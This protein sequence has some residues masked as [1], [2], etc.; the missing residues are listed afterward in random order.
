MFFPLCVRMNQMNSPSRRLLQFR[1]GTL[2]LVIAAFALGLAARNIADGLH[3]LTMSLSLPKSNTPLRPG[4]VLLV[5]SSVDKAINRK[6]TV[7]ADCSVSL[8]F[9][10]D[11]SV[12]GMTLKTLEQ[13]LNKQYS[14]LYRSPN[15]QVFRANVSEPIP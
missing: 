4:D 11:L 15:I 14:K 6:V 9:V 2:L 5:E 1:L 13:R 8:P 10:G 12:K 7:L 3:P